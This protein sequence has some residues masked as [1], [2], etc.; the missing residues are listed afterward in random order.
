MQ[1]ETWAWLLAHLQEIY[2]GTV[3]G[4]VGLTLAWS[5]RIIR[6]G[7]PGLGGREA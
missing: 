7:R 2:Q 1:P 4:G 3:V 6:L 5:S